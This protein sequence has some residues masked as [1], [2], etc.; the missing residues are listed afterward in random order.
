MVTPPFSS[1]LTLDV[2]MLVVIKRMA[3]LLVMLPT[4]TT[5]K[6]VVGIVLALGAETTVL[7]QIIAQLAVPEFT[8]V[9]LAVALA[10]LNNTGVLVNPNQLVP[11]RKKLV[12]P[13]EPVCES[14]TLV[15][16]VQVG[17]G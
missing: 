6:F 15:L 11:L 14:V 5:M 8:G 13:L 12:P 1:R 16:A 9:T 10:V 3:A 2:L 17:A 7:S 4:G